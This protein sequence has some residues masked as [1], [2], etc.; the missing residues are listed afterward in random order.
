MKKI[1]KVIGL[2][3][4]IAIVATGVYYVA[5][6]EA[7]PKGVQGKE[8]EK[9]AKKMMSAINKSAFDHTEILEWSFK[10]NIIMYGKNNRDW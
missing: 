9:L 5:N 8:A 6:N 7:L 4:T 10:G 2:F 3:I 1:L